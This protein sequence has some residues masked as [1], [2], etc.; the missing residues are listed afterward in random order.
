LK[1]CLKRKLE[2]QFGQKVNVAKLKCIITQILFFTNNTK[3]T[4]ENIKLN[5]RL[6][7]NGF[8]NQNN[9]H[10]NKFRLL[11]RRIQDMFSNSVRKSDDCLKPYFLV[12]IILKNFNFQFST[13]HLNGV[14]TK[15]SLN[16]LPYLSF[17]QENKNTYRLNCKSKESL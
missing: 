4:K 6:L 14:T 8:I 1:S 15:L 9:N 5:Q 10:K 16:D 3:S 13:M 11:M 7:Q 17:E 12:Y 2:N